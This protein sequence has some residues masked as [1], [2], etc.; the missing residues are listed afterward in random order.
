MLAY[1]D[2]LKDKNTDKV[3][4]EADIYFQTFHQKCTIYTLS[5]LN[6][7]SPAVVVYLTF[8][9]QVAHFFGD[10]SLY[11]FYSLHIRQYSICL[12]VAFYL[13]ATHIHMHI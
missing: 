11:N 7:V 9:Q 13:Q 12:L 6:C 10:E 8:C 3:N 2:L 4:Y 5:I 1:C